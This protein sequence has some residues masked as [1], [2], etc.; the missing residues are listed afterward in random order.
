QDG[1]LDLVVT[2]FGGGSV[3]VLLGNGDGTFQAPTS[4]A[5][6]SQPD[7]VVAG[8]FNGD[9]YPDLGVDNFGS[10][11]VSRL[12]NDRNWGGAGGGGQAPRA[13]AGGLQA[14]DANFVIAA[15]S[16]SVL[17]LPERMAIQASMTQTV[18]SRDASA[19]QAPTSG[20]P[21]TAGLHLELT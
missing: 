7:F 9:G 8:D 3:S 2:N 14:A 12:L 13:P 20:L 21:G 1:N 4:Y 10:G 15:T 17:P 6:G 19:A 18:W 11:G 16:G 5:V